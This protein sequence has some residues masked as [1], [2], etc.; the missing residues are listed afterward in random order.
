LIH[1][2]SELR[3]INPVMGYGLFATKTIPK[4]TVTWVGDPLD[5]V[6]DRR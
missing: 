3:F 5:L 6:C 4:G 1:P 2:D